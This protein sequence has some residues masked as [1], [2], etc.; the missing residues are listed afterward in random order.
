MN[1]LQRS[2]SQCHDDASED[3]D[4]VVHAPTETLPV[5]MEGRWLMPSLIDRFAETRRDWVSRLPHDWEMDIDRPDWLG[6]Q[7]DRSHPKR[8]R[9]TVQEFVALTCRSPC[10]CVEISQQ[11]HWYYTCCLQ[12]VGLGRVR[13]VIAFDDLQQTGGYAV[14]LSNRLD[15]SPR[16]LLSRWL[17]ARSTLYDQPIA[18]RSAKVW[19]GMVY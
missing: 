15:W 6:V 4:Q 10:Q 18:R 9:F 11:W 8:T 13:A 2:T 17:E 14:L 19:G 7:W 3:A 16:S 5:L 1:G 12:V